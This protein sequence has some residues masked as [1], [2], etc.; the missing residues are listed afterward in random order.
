MMLPFWLHI[1]SRHWFQ[2]VRFPWQVI[3]GLSHLSAPPRTGGLGSQIQPNTSREDGN[4]RVMMYVSLIT[5]IMQNGYIGLYIWKYPPVGRDKSNMVASGMAFISFRNFVIQPRGP[6][7]S[8]SRHLNSSFKW[9]F[10]MVFLK[11]LRKT[12]SGTES[13]T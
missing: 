7:I 8:M 4:Y 13:I 5:R 12:H 2:G 3:Y 9:Y 6:Q 1:C 10:K 11:Q